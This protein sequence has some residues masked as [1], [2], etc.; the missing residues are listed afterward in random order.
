MSQLEVKALTGGDKDVSFVDDE[1]VSS[2]SSVTDQILS[3]LRAS[4]TLLAIM[5]PRYLSSQWCLSEWNAFKDQR[6]G[7]QQNILPVIWTPLPEALPEPFTNIQFSGLHATIFICA[8]GATDNR[9][10]Q[11]DAIPVQSRSRTARI[12][13]R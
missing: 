8:R 10:T 13:Y 1:N 3:A 9:R 7:G 5:T 12:A 6:Q 2:S 4:R 11:S